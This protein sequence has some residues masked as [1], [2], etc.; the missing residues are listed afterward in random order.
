M[1]S[2]SNRPSH[3]VKGE[4]VAFGVQEHDSEAVGADLMFGLEDLAAA[5]F[6]GGTYGACRGD[7]GMLPT[8]TS[9][10]LRLE[11]R[12]SPISDGATPT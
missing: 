10:T 8:S 6:D 9:T 3:R 7:I 4:A 5:W 12:M 1:S 11:I 2:S